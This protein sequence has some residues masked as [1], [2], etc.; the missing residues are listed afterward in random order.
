MRE[1]SEHGKTLSAR[2]SEMHGGAL[3]FRCHAKK[4]LWCGHIGQ[5]R[6]SHIG[7]IVMGREVAGVE[8][9]SERVSQV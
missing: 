7:R 4:Q 2:A 9:G 6:V 3:A 8:L 1:K 5:G